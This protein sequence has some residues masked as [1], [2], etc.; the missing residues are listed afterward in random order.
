[1]CE[2]ASGS[3]VLCA[4]EEEFAGCRAV[5]CAIVWGGIGSVRML[6]V[7][8]CMREEAGGVRGR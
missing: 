7:Y 2:E 1:M 5:V 6:C 3:G 8:V 4:C